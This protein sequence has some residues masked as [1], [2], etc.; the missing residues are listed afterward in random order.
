VFNVFVAPLEGGSAECVKQLLTL[1]GFASV[2]R[3][4][5]FAHACTAIVFWTSVLH[6]G[7]ANQRSSDS[8]K[9]PRRSNSCKQ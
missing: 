5:V 8:C 7:F 9:C 4:C 6:M 2:F 1:L 3:E